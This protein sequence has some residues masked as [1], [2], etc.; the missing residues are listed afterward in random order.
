M[1]FRRIPTGMYY[2]HVTLT[3]VFKRKYEKKR[4]KERTIDQN[5]YTKRER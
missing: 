4:L 3:K 2:L 1:G 5:I